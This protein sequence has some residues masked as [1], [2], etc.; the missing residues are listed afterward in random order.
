MRVL[1]DT[2]VLISVFLGSAVCLE[3]L[4]RCRAEHTLVTTSVIV[5]EFAEKLS[6]KFRLG[7][8]DVSAAVLSAFRM[9]QVIDDLPEATPFCRDPDDALVLGAAIAG[10][11][12][13]LITGDE[14]LLVLKEV[15]GVRILTPR[16]FL[17]LVD[18]SGDRD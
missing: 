8:E 5:E 17:N 3:V 14:D 13:L 9:M 7:I 4:D 12:D 1:L 11:C 6:R 10:Q 18:S 16:E 15:Q 2:N